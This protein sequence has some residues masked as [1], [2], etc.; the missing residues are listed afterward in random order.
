[1]AGHVGGWLYD[2]DH[3]PERWQRLQAMLSSDEPVLAMRGSYE[4]V[5]IDPRQF[6]KVEN[7]GSVGSCQGHS[8]S[9]CVEWCY[10]IATG[11]EKLQL[12]RAYGYYET[13]R[14]DGITGDRG[15][16]IEGGVKLATQYGICREELWPYSGR[17]EPTRPRPIEEL[18]ADAAQYKIG[19]TYSLKSY[20]AIRTFLG[21]GQGAVHLGITWNS[22]V[23]SGSVNSYSG[24]GGGGHAIG[25]YALS[26]KKDSSGRP[27][28]WMMN[29]WGGSWGQS[30]WSEWSPNAVSQMMAARW[31]VFIGV[32]DMPNLT[33]RKFTVEEWKRGLRV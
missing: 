13:Q 7:Q 4:E 2:L 5:S 19:K 15:S 31:S 11:G 3:E 24:A 9:S 27:W 22:S 20:D 26:T 18:R 23:D 17:Y 8:I 33:P 10:A 29:S 30:G 12:S 14:L 32:S 21:S 16:T 28:L 1:M 25:L 6:M